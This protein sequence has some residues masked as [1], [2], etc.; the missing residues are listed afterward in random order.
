[1]WPFKR[2][3]STANTWQIK[4]ITYNDCSFWH[5]I[6]TYDLFHGSVLFILLYPMMFL[7]WINFIPRS[8][9]LPNKFICPFG[10][11]T[12]SFWSKNTLLDPFEVSTPKPVTNE[13]C[14]EWNSLMS[15]SPTSHS[16]QVDKSGITDT[17]QEASC[18]KVAWD[19]GFAK[20]Q[21]AEQHKEPSL[22]HERETLSGALLHCRTPGL[23][24]LHQLHQ[25]PLIKNVF[26]V[27]KVIDW[28][29]LEGR[30]S[31]P[32][33]YSEQSPKK[34][35]SQGCVQSGFAHLQRVLPWGT[36]SLMFNNRR[37]GTL[38]IL[39]PICWYYNLYQQ[40]G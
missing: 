39:Y 4:F 19:F 7:E 5:F 28:L 8:N 25:Q 40:I 37:I 30:S 12:G 2:N 29:S 24:S 18:L 33:L 14:S 20:G 3:I 23:C 1:M 22:I 11:S 31:S 6:S 15:I 35:V 10:C 27:H 9:H 38:P 17:A 34:T 36:F 13:D 21:K 26:E 16:L 32:D